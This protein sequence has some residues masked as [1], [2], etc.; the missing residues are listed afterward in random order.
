MIIRS[1]GGNISL[2]EIQVVI[3]NML[4]FIHMKSDIDVLI[5][6]YWCLD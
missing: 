3:S 2:M 5:Q 1:K 6:Y 4:K